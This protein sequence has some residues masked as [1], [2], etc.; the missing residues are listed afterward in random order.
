M[1]NSWICNYFN[2]L[3]ICIWLHQLFFYF[4]FRLLPL[5]MPPLSPIIDTACLPIPANFVHNSIHSLTSRNSFDNLNKVTIRN[6]F[7]PICNI[8]MVS[9]K[10]FMRFH[11]LSPGT[12]RFL[13]TNRNLFIPHSLRVHNLSF[14]SK[15]AST[16]QYSSVF[17]KRQPCR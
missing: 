3:P 2:C 10:T 1:R 4:N 6:K 5:V 9:T 7:I 14:T 8:E 17:L 15:W 16:H 13:C 11:Y 12:K